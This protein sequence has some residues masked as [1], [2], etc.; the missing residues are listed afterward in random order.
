MNKRARNRLIAVTV[1]ILVAVVTAV[2]LSG[3]KQGA[4]YSDVKAVTSDSSLIGKRVKVGGT[5]IAGSWDKKSNPMTFTIR[6]ENDTSGTGPTLK[7]VYTGAAPSTF[8][9][10]VVAIVTGKLGDD[11][12]L[13]A[14]EMITKCPSKYQSATDAMPIADLVNGGESLVGKPV[15][16]TGYVKPGSLKAADSDERFI[17]AEKADGSGVTVPV[18]FSGGLADD[19]KDGVKV[20][21]SG[22]IDE[23]GRFIATSVALGK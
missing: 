3:T 5:V 23:N 14:T 18:V 22:E 17:V 16:A 21:V 2:L 11:G 9:D 10:G 7:V 19:I 1:V 8:G 4:V 12:V 20:I 6:A 15:K 13:Q